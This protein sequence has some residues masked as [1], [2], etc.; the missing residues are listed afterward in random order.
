MREGI[1]DACDDERVQQIE[2]I[3]GIAEQ[4]NPGSGERRSPLGLAGDAVD[5]GG[6]GG[7]EKP[8]GQSGVGDERGEGD[9]RGK[10]NEAGENQWRGEL[11]DVCAR[12]EK[13]ACKH[14]DQELRQA[15]EWIKAED[16]FPK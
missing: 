15:D 9:D 1:E 14:S 3:A 11:S 16:V 13:F 5:D 10:T 12:Q 8:R 2:T 6:E 7:R 4:R